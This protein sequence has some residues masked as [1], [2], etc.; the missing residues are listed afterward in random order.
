MHFN[1]PVFLF[2]FFCLKVHHGCFQKTA[3]VCK[4]ACV[5][6][7]YT[8][9][10]KS[11]PRYPAVDINIARVNLHPWG[12]VSDGGTLYCAFNNT[13]ACLFS[14]LTLISESAVLGPRVL[15]W[16]R[17]RLADFN[18]LFIYPRRF[19]WAEMKAAPPREHGPRCHALIVPPRGPSPLPDWP[20]AGPLLFCE[21]PGAIILP[22][23]RCPH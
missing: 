15:L 5:A 7:D 21:D 14:V 4:R 22:E 9:S 11:L 3:R 18:Y 2:F 13:L 17:A 12:A 1:E 23:C 6:V 10:F 8:F 20:P 16:S 19:A